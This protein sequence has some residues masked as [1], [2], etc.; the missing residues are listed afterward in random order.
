MNNN[1]TSSVESKKRA[2]LRVLQATL[3]LPA[4]V[5]FYGAALASL[6]MAIGADL[7][8]VLAGIAGGVGVNAL[9]S[10]LERVARGQASDDEIRE[11]LQQ[12]IAD[13]GI[14][15]VL[16]QRDLEPMLA[17][18]FRRL[19]IL[20]YALQK[21]DLEIIERLT[22]SSERHEAFAAE[23][24]DELASKMDSLATRE[25]GAKILENLEHLRKLW[26]T[27]ALSAIP[28]SE[29]P[30]R[31]LP[32][33]GRD[34][35]FEWLRGTVDDKLLLG[36]PGSGKTFILQQ[37]TNEASAFFVNSSERSL[38]EKEIEAKNPDILIVDDAEVRREL[39]LDLKQLRTTMRKQFTIIASGWPSDKKVLADSLN[40]SNSQIRELELLTRDEMVKVIESTG[41][42]GPNQLIFELVNQAEGRPGLAATLADLYL[43]GDVRTIVFGDAISNSLLKYLDKSIGQQATIILGAFAIGGNHGMAKQDVADQLRMPLIDL[44]VILTQLSTGG[45]VEDRGYGRLAVRPPALRGILLKEVMFISTSMLNSNALVHQAPWLS[46]AVSTLID[47]S[48]RGAIISTDYLHRLVEEANDPEV[49]REYAALGDRQTRWILSNHPDQVINVAGA[50]LYHVPQVSLP[51]LFS[52]AINNNRSLSSYPEHPLRLVQAWIQSSEPRTNQAVDRRKLTLDVAQTWVAQGNDVG[53]GV[54]ALSIAFSPR[55]EDSFLDPGEGNTVTMRRGIIPPDDLASVVAMWPKAANVLKDTIIEDW[56]YLQELAVA[57][58]YPGRMGV[59]LPDSTIDLMQ[60]F[61]RQILN[62]LLP[63]ANGRLDIIHWMHQLHHQLGLGANLPLDSDFETLHPIRESDDWRADQENQ[64]EAVDSLVDRWAGIEPETVAERLYEI[65]NAARRGQIYGSNWTDYLCTQLAWRVSLRLQWAVAMYKRGNS[66]QLIFPFLQQAAKNNEVGWTELAKEFLG[67]PM[68][69]AVIHVVLKQPDPPAD[70]LSAVLTNLGGYDEV[71]KTII[72]RNEVPESTVQKLLEH[73]DDSVASAAAYG[74]WFSEPKNSVRDSLKDVWDSAVLRVTDDGYLLTEIFMK[75]P[76]LA[77]AWLQ[78]HL[79]PKYVDSLSQYSP[80]GAAIVHLNIES[81]RS[82]LD[83]TP[84]DY[85]MR[86]IVVALVDDKIDLYRDLLGKKHLDLFHLAPLGQYPEGFWIEKAK[87]AREAG[88]SA[89]DVVHAVYQAPHAMAWTGNASSMWADWVDR[90]Q[91]LISN[92]DSRIREIGEIGKA[93]AETQL[94]EALKYERREAIYGRG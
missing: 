50:A 54:H 76:A 9:S 11:Q 77:Y 61:A 48:R 23:M 52:Q 51:M 83:M 15:G 81:R 89:E 63:L 18:M 21:Q 64:R 49:W 17:R 86:D 41:I 56:Q 10:I 30:L 25:Q 26:S 24:H 2:L 4:Q 91:Q 19:D 87:A 16:E 66:S 14:G 67:S 57:W 47:S 72:L 5:T 58:A 71:I 68:K 85:R 38:I 27:S 28:K 12:A 3:I 39:L 74:E 8:P 73:T 75:Y 94:V 84:P 31:N 90:F 29:R 42:S 22:A 62:D 44:Q 88:Y 40:L 70:L 92:E 7:P 93:D 59:S 60:S 69:G 78:R 53:V 80:F 1:D 34:R 55:Y 65:E 45:L 32:M 46:D 37:L 6:A 35:E 13:S 20:E 43:K 33:I 36:Q 79:D 82:L